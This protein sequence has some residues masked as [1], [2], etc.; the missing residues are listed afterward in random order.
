MTGDCHAGH[1]SPDGSSIQQVKEILAPLLSEFRYGRHRAL[2]DKLLIELTESRIEHRLLSLPIPLGEITLP[3]SMLSHGAYYFHEML[4]TSTRTTRDAR[5][6]KKHEAEEKATRPS[7]SFV[8]LSYA[9]SDQQ[10]LLISESS[11]I[12][13]L[14]I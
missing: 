6:Q 8:L 3:P 2:L 7:S 12:S 13:L 9:P 11:I 4:R 14:S 1:A 10:S 5:L